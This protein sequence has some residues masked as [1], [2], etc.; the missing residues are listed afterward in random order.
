MTGTAITRHFASITT[1]RFGARQ[2]H[3]R[4]CGAGPVVILFHQSPLSSVD[5]IT[6]MRR[7]AEHFTCIAPDSPGFG[8]SDPLGVTHAEMRDFADAALEFMDALG[9]ERAAVYGFHTGAMI[10]AA[11]AAAY[12]E[13]IACAAAN[14]YVMLAEGEKLDIAEHYLP[15]FRPAWDGS[16]LTWLWARMREQSIFFPWYAKSLAAR[17]RGNVPPPATLHAGLLDF[18]RSGDHYRVGYRAAFLMRSDLALREMRVPALITAYDTDVLAAH[19][20]RIRHASA[21]VTVQ[22]GGTVEQT[23]DVCRDFLLRHPPS[24]GPKI[25]PPLALRGRL[26]QDFVSLPGG[27]LRLRRNDEGTGRTVLVLHDALGSSDTIASVAAGFIGHRPVVALEL[28]G[29]G[30][31]DDLLPADTPSIAA[32]AQVVAAALDALALAD[33]DVVGLGAGAVIALE[34]ALLDRSR[35]HALAMVGVAEVDRDRVAEV[36]AQIAPTLE[37]DWFGGYLLQAWHC[38]R[39]Q[40]LFWP[41]YERGTRG[42]VLQEPQ[43][44]PVRLQQRLLEVFRSRGNWGRALKAQFA[45]PLADQL[46]RVGE[47]AALPLLFAASDLDVHRDHTWRLAGQVPQA[48]RLLLPDAEA[49][50]ASTLLGGFDGLRR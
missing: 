40:A 36:S 4:R 1:G 13:R 21:S 30:E 27:Q 10:S 23:L 26:H 5:M 35:V 39:D 45:Y 8:V 9:I 22:A 25:S 46:A 18:M 48:P 16:H 33:C 20:P 7:W 11:I 44:D 34:L 49:K 3:Y 17:L 47:S 29:H 42:L 41:W 19:L 50:W 38:V 37:P 43:L 2:V 31:S 24:A 12:P 28:P 14:G 6:T 15:A 32:Y